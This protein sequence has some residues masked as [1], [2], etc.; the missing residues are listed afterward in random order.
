MLSA[1]NKGSDWKKNKPNSHQVIGSDAFI[2]ASSTVFTNNLQGLN[3]NVNSLL[4]M[5]YF[6][7]NIRAFVFLFS[8]IR[9]YTW[10]V[11]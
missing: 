2:T 3:G 6:S 10:K 4:I 5:N 8:Y 1:I 11:F 7:V 9:E